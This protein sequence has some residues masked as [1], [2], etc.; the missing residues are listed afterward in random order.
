MDELEKRIEELTIELGKVPF[1]QAAKRKEITEEIK[2]LSELRLEYEKVDLNRINNNIR[3]D[4]D[5]ER[6][7]I[8]REKLKVAKGHPI[9]DGI[10]AIAP[11]VQ[12]LAA[13][14]LAVISFKGEWVEGL[15]RDRTSWNLANN[16]FSKKF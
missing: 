2:T 3:N 5:Q 7:E 16:L 10:K 1:D 4:L 11:F 15:I 13:L 8:E 12:I 6:N 14:G 9:L